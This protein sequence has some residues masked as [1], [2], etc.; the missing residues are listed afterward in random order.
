[1]FVFEI[2]AWYFVLLWRIFPRRKK[3]IR[4]ARLKL[5]GK[6]TRESTRGTCCCQI[7]D[8]NGKQKGTKM[9]GKNGPRNGG[10]K[11]E[12]VISEKGKIGDIVK[13]SSQLG[14]SNQWFGAGLVG[15]NCVRLALIRYNLFWHLPSFPF[16]CW[17]PNRLSLSK[18][19]FWDV[20]FSGLNNNGRPKWMM[21][22]KKDDER[23]KTAGLIFFL[24]SWKQTS[25]TRVRALPW[26]EK[27]NGEEK[28]IYLTKV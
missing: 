1:M 15:A 23:R 16:L 7:R 13:G 10:G 8:W 21:K 25:R 9:K 18:V 4:N 11:E 22:M 20:C 5:M 28:K 26:L 2:K 6:K 14:G 27:T 19:P 12:K 24:P 3:P 17:P